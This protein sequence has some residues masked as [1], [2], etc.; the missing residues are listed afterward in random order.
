M[1]ALSALLGATRPSSKLLRQSSA[2]LQIIS[3]LCI[4]FLGIARPQPDFH[5]RVFVSDLYFPRIGPHL[6]H[7]ADIFGAVLPRY[8]FAFLGAALRSFSN[9]SLQGNIDLRVSRK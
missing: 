7:A 1:S 8:F 4:P 6:F 5:I 3:H 2:T 9:H